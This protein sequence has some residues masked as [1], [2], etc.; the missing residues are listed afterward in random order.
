M[1][2]FDA[3]GFPYCY[4]ITP[5]HSMGDIQVT[6]EYVVHAIRE[7]Q[8]AIGQQR[9]ESTF[10]KALNSGGETFPGIDYTVAWTDYDQVLNPPGKPIGGEPTRIDGATNIRLQDI[11]PGNTADHVAIGSYDPVA[12][13]IMID[14]LTHPGPADPARIDR[15]VCAQALPPHV[16][17]VGFPVNYA[18]VWAEIWTQLTSS[19]KVDAEPALKAY[20]QGH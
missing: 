4:V 5:G 10:I 16:D 12:Y 11:C 13:A 8:P 6:S 2:E 17:P 1:R 9:Y 3:L 18:K 14:A 19:P 7:V 15:A 20:A